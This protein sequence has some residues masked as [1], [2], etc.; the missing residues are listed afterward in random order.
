[1][2]PLKMIIPGQYWDSQLYQGRLY[3][4][5]LDGSLFAIDWD[6]VIEEE[7]KKFGQNF[8]FVCAFSRGDYLYGENWNLIFNDVDVKTMVIKKFATL[9]NTDIL[10]NQAIIDRYRRTAKQNPM[11][12]PHADCTIY[13]QKMYVGSPSG[14]FQSGCNQKTVGPISSRV[15]KLSDLPTQ[16]V[17]A[18]WRNLAIAS[19]SEGLWQMDLEPVFD[20]GSFSG[21][22]DDRT[23]QLSEIGCTACEWNSFDVFGSSNEAGGY[24]ASFTL[25]RSVPSSSDDS[26][27]TPQWGESERNRVFEELI[28][29]EAIFDTDGYAFG[30]GDKIY[31][32]HKDTLKAGP[33]HLNLR[34]ILGGPVANSSHRGR[35]VSASS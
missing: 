27:S 11:P 1:M 13:E 16:S 5:G 33:A 26:Y 32:I 6:R 9:S 30:F 21:R 25:Q 18:G 34:Q 20:A 31:Q 15:K 29:A 7:A 24:L 4:F 2:Q 17:S 19:G 23:T 35:H 14:V 12:F 22:S 28:S 3:L 10:L 8:A